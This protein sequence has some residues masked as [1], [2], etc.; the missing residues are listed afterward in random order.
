MKALFQVGD[1]VKVPLG[2]GQG[3]G[4]ISEDRGPIGIRGGHLYQVLVPMDPFEPAIFELAEDEIE[5]F[6]QATEVHRRPIEKEKI[7]HYLK[8]G[9]LISILQSGASGG[10]IAPRVWLCRDQLG[11]LTHTFAQER[12]VVG[13]ETVPSW[14]AQFGSIFKSKQKEVA[15]LLHSFGL[16]VKQAADVI[17]AVGIVTR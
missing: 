8:L 15:S 6:P 16:D 3:A 12:G 13:G 7:I 17:R 5:A 11:N 10:G 9:G 1:P 14:A 2:R 4:V